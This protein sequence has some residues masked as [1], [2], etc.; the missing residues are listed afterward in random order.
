MPL[1][2]AHSLWPRIEPLL[3]RAERPS[4]YIGQEF[5]HA[6]KPDA[7]YRAAFVYP[8]AYEIG[9]SNQAV[10]LLYAAANNMP[11]V[12][13]ERAFLPWLDM[14]GL[15]R[16]AGIPLFSLES[17]RPLAGFD[18]IGITIPHEMAA[19][20]ILE[21]MDLAGLP[22]HSAQRDGSH[23]LVVGGGPG[24]YNPEP[25]AP[26][27][28][29][30]AIGESEELV[31]ELI[32]AH[33]R[34]A[35]ASR[36]ELLKALSGIDGLY[37]PSLHSTDSPQNVSRRVFM[38]FSWQ[39]PEDC[40]VPYTEVTHDRLTIEV[41]RGCTRGCRFCQAGMTYRPVRER[42]SDAI[43]AAA[44]S[45]I[46][47]SGFDEVSLASLSTTD[48]SR[49]EP[50][51]RRLNG[52]F[53]GTGVSVSLPSQR[54]DAFGVEMAYSVAGEKKPGLTF[55]PEA[56][57]Q[58]LRDVIN[59]NVTEDDLFTAVQAAYT[60]GFRRCKLYFMIG[61]PTET[62]DDV[63]AIV[64]LVN[65]AFALA[66]DSVPDD[67]RGQVRMQASVAVFVPKASTP[68]Q[69]CGQL[70]LAEV[71][72]RI[73]LLRD[74]GLRKGVDLSWHDPLVSQVEAALSLSG[75][76]A[77]ALIEAAWR[78]GAL[79]AAWSDQ[80][81]YRQWLAAAEASGLDLAGMAE[82]A[83]PQEAELPWQHVSSGVTLA[84]LKKEWQRALSGLTT[85]DCSLEACQA[86]G[87]CDETEPLILLERP[88]GLGSLAAF[89]T[90]PQDGLAAPTP[91]RTV[92]EARRHE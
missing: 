11:G 65:R 53:R 88:N 77:A 4:R 87:V 70:P 34:L 81:D 74:G 89:G 50:I 71:Q 54:L 15:M 62:D 28:D 29:C 46:A 1:L 23:P 44:T 49:I 85:P 18:L 47:A 90:A 9:Q 41:L 42:P 45:G 13:A 55:A 27:F 7:T 36:H 79:F 39:M 3:P 78:G 48:H 30:I 76:E 69:W 33:R 66:R 67:Q 57:S 32:D 17:A 80:F 58:R 5:N 8:D 73:G 56:G 21:V 83:Y 6:Y 64:D 75:R 91:I 25:L 24:C 51:L 68:F 16:E 84:Y 22:L 37:V 82:R 59:K 60:A 40:L 12:G 26:F 19:T 31:V 20:N 2:D 35:A 92:L 14:A 43:I 61:L 10:A 63:L 38:G 52:R 72:R 86:C